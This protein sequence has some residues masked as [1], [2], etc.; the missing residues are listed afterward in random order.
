MGCNPMLGAAR[1]CENHVYV[2]SSTHTDVKQN[3]MI[4]A[5]YGHDGVPL[6]QA[7]EWGTLA[8]AEVDLDRRL[9]WS[10]LGDFKAEVPRHR[11]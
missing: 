6:A 5:V 3:W 9:L 8:I 4:S 10:S 7:T 1:A 2:V 11:P